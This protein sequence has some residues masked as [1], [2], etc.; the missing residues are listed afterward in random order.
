MLAILSCRLKSV[1]RDINS[2]DKDLQL[3]L[4]RAGPKAVIV[5]AKQLKRTMAITEAPYFIFFILFFQ[6]K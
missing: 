5:A 6:G 1:C 4:P 3:H 2:F